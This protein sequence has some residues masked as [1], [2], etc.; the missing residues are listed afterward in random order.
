MIFHAYGQITAS[1]KN[2][3]T[4]TNNSAELIAFTRALQ[5]AATRGDISH[6]VM[7]YDSLYAAIDHGASHD[8]V[9]ESREGVPSFTDTHA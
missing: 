4:I 1:T 3:Q 8:S 6:I 7:I 2:I 9:P 5:W